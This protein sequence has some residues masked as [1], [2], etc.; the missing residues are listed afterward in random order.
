MTKKLLLKTAAGAAAAALGVAGAAGAVE[1]EMEVGGR[2]YAVTLAD[3]PGTASLMAQLPITVTFEDYGA[4]ERIAYLKTPLATDGAPTSTKPKV[5]D[6]TYYIPWGNLAVFVRPFRESNGLMPLGHL[7]PEALAAIQ[8]SG[9]AK[10]V[11]R[12]KK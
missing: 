3:H 4:N 12:A 11:F 9:D 2:T 1:L 5:G 6:I 7:T 10:V 8:T